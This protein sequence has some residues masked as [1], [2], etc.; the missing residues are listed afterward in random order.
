MWGA[1]PVLAQ[2]LRLCAECAGSVLRHGGERKIFGKN[3]LLL[4]QGASPEKWMLEVGEYTIK[5]FAALYGMEYG[6]MA[7]NREDG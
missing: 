7:T 3:S 5:R 2:Y 6:G 1:P 4:F